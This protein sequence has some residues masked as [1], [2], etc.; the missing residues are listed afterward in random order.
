[1]QPQH[2]NQLKI[3]LTFGSRVSLACRTG[4]LQALM[5]ELA[6]KPEQVTDVVLVRGM[7]KMKTFRFMH[8]MFLRLALVW[9]ERGIFL[10][11]ALVWCQRG[12]GPG[13][14][15]FACSNGHRRPHTLLPSPHCACRRPRAVLLVQYVA[16]LRAKRPL[17]G[18]RNNLKVASDCMRRW[19]RTW[20]GVPRLAALPRRRRWR[21]L[22]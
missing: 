8:C 1:M 11:N 22:W 19:G 21:L 10:L 13:A 12:E 2:S 18:R 3:E 4:P 15:L 17:L 16:Y 14:Y 6:I 9:C 7:A 20:G 5:D